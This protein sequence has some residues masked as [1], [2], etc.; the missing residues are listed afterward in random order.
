MSLRPFSSFTKIII[1]ATFNMYWV[2]IMSQALNSALH[3]CQSSPRSYR[4]TPVLS[5]FYFWLNWGT[6]RLRNVPNDT[7]VVR[8]EAG[9]Q[10]LAGCTRLLTTKLCSFSQ[11]FL[12]PIYSHEFLDWSSE[13]GNDATLSYLS[14]TIFT[15]PYFISII[16][17]QKAQETMRRDSISSLPK[18]SLPSKSS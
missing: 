11:C 9:I 1:T 16:N 14:W 15:K 10:T 13:W 5:L 18:I 7:Q 2:L 4:L 3:E 6:G 17:S 12:F 8:G